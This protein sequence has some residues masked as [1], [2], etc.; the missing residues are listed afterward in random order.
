MYLSENSQGFSHE[1]IS[2]DQF[3]Q[4]QRKKKRNEIIFSR[5]HFWQRHRQVLAPYNLDFKV[6]LM[7]IFYYCDIIGL[8]ILT[9]VQSNEWFIAHAI[10][11]GLFLVGSSCFMLFNLSLN[12]RLNRPE[13]V[14][15]KEKGVLFISLIMIHPSTPSFLKSQ[16]LGTIKI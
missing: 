1:I 5:L 7:Y 16:V 8:I 4:I 2:R 9:Y 11:F 14:T 3:G 13:I 12:A 6:R 15:L 10:G